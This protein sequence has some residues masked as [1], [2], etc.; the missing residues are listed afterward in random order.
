MI[1]VETPCMASLHAWRLSCMA[2]I[3][4]WRLYIIKVAGGYHR[5]RPNAAV[6]VLHQPAYRTG[7]P[8]YG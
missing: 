6:G 4:A 8:Q 5:S 1:P 3:H 7:R 2:S